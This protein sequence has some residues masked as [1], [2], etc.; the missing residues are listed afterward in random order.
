L[1]SEDYVHG[2]MDGWADRAEY[3]KRTQLTFD[4]GVEWGWYS[5]RRAMRNALAEA[6]QGIPLDAARVIESLLRKAL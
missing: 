4:D 5:A 3:A 1:D 6:C 2:F